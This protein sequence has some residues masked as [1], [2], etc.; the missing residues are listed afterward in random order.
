[1]LRKRA[2]ALLVCCAASTVAFALGLGPLQSKSALNEPFAGRINV[3]GATG[4]DIDS[5]KILLASPED[6]ERAGAQLNPVLYKLR[7]ALDTDDA[8]NNLISVTSREPIREP[9]LNFLLDVNWSQGRLLREYTVLLDPPLYAPGAPPQAASADLAPP[10]RQ[11]PANVADSEEPQAG[12]DL[13]STTATATASGQIGPV[14]ANDTLWALAS[15]HRPDQGISVQQMMLAMLREN[16]EAFSRGNINLLQRGAVLRLPS[17]AALRELSAAEA[18]AEVRHQHELWQSYRQQ[19]ASNPSSQSLGASA[20]T[21][22][23]PAAPSTQTE[24]RLELVAPGGGEG[25]GNASGEASG[26]SDAELLREELAAHS[27]QTQDLKG[28]LTEAEEI[29]D[30]LQRQVNIKDEEL[31]ALQ[32]RLVE[33][34]VE[35]DPADALGE[36]AT[37]LVEESEAVDGA[38]EVTLSSPRTERETA[39]TMQPETQNFPLNLVPAQIAAQVPGGAVAVLGALAFLLLLVLVLVLRALLRAKKA[40]G[41]KASPEQ[42]RAPA[43]EAVAVAAVTEM[44]DLTDGEETTRKSTE[45]LDPNTTAIDLDVRDQ[46]AA[47]ES[48]SESPASESHLGVENVE[49]EEEL[50]PLEE[51]NVYLAYERFDQAEQLVKEVIGEHPDRH[52]YKLR[53]LE[54]YYSANDRAAYETAARDLQAAV[55]DED[56]LWVTAVAMWSEMSPDR[57]LFADGDDLS[58][59]TPQDDSA[60]TFVDLT[61]EDEGTTENALDFDL[62]G[63]EDDI[64]DSTPS[65][66]SSADSED[67]VLDLTQGQVPESD[68]DLAVTTPR[69]EVVAAADAD[70]LDITSLGSEGALADPLDVTADN[71][72]A[73]DL[74]FDLGVDG[75]DSQDAH[76]D[77][78]DD[79]FMDITGGTASGGLLEATGAPVDAGPDDEELLDSTPPLR[80]EPLDALDGDTLDEVHQDEE[81]EL[82]FDISGTLASAFGG[83]EEGAADGSTTSGEL[84]E[85]SSDFDIG[86]LDLGDGADTGAILGDLAVA[87]ETAEES[88]AGDEAV[89]LDIDLDITMDGGE[90]SGGLGVVENE[91]AEGHLEITMTSLVDD[92]S[93]LLDSSESSFEQAEQEIAPED[94]DADIEFDI[95]LDATTDMESLA[96]TRTAAVESLLDNTANYLQGGDADD[97]LEDLDIEPGELDLDEEPDASGEVSFPESDDMAGADLELDMDFE[98]TM[99]MAAEPDNSDDGVD[100]PADAD[101]ADTKLNLARA[102]I[103]LGDTDGAATIL[104]EVMEQGDAAQQTEAE[105]LLQGLTE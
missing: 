41:K 10:E 74:D 65:D 52:E 27:Q 103:E 98:Q 19:V 20:V 77:G 94:D 72:E 6:F 96:A 67:D 54:V 71:A 45:A 100:I 83:D 38:T 39:P 93:D 53:L 43:S 55:G 12:S 63:P 2:V 25:V 97:E 78:T 105:T 62:G 18:I 8:G 46:Q 50:D 23:D 70:V 4:D 102:Y 22:P 68:S 37:E 33:L 92:G 76:G 86:D 88:L 64:L 32:A 85:A 5:L 60:K 95:A 40:G 51:M 57:A 84:G 28:K 81:A 35:E 17:D 24:A 87:A 16:P 1:M 7:F 44:P 49:A 73:L 101:E 47:R 36:A 13:A 79:D 30:L 58:D 34:G 3:I 80:E 29:I 11:K 42:K 21:E 26:T 9:F 15:R 59:A 75:P 90:G 89:D 14:G 82:D 99:A 104:R 31:A 66:E 61:A 48:I 91:D 56:P 69:D